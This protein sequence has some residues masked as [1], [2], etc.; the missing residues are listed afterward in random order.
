MSSA[1]PRL[2][3]FLGLESLATRA[4]AEAI[5]RSPADLELLR[6]A[7]SSLMSFT[8]FEE[9]SGASRRLL[10][11]APRD[12]DAWGLLVLCAA[13]CGRMEDA[14]KAAERLAELRPGECEPRLL[15]ALVMRKRHRTLAAMKQ[16][17]IA[18]G[19]PRSPIGRRFLL[20][21]SLFGEQ[22]W[23]TALADCSAARPVGRDEARAGRSRLD[24]PRQLETS[25]AAATEV[26]EG[27]Q[28]PG[29]TVRWLATGLRWISGRRRHPEDSLRLLRQGWLHLLPLPRLR[30]QVGEK[31]RSRP[32]AAAALAVAWLSFWP[33]LE[34]RAQSPEPAP[35]L[36]ELPAVVVPATVETAVARAALRNCFLESGE[37]GIQACQSALARG[38]TRGKALGATRR[39]AWLQAL[40]YRWHEATRAWAA[41]VRISPSDPELRVS[42]GQL[43]LVLDRPAEALVQF[44]QALSLA[45]QE[46]EALV[47]LGTAQARLG[48][49]EQAASSFEQALGLDP[50]LFESRPALQ[51]VRDSVRSGSAWP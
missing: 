29:R 23:H 31:P 12:A 24:A 4:W 19:L 46:V 41:A 26:A 22:A 7:I 49:R 6:G 33:A 30:S 9:A 34:A 17:R 13:K 51:A 18:A 39:L 28:V 35:P 36:P 20:G 21:E 40:A 48:L 32:G 42:L 3:G 27:A 15:L 44:Q 10:R 45:P 11:L 8:R 47:G 14:E 16:F 1:L 25:V 38:L 5:V 43:W 37:T 50:E 2:L